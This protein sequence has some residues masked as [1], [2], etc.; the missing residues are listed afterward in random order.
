[1][2]S[3]QIS[4]GNVLVS[5]LANHNTD[6]VDM[7]KKLENSAPSTFTL[8]ADLENE[9]AD[10]KPLECPENFFSNVNASGSFCLPICGEFSFFQREIRILHKV[11]MCVCFIASVIMIVITFTIQRKKT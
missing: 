6:V 11:V 10:G 3:Y 9:I 1:M 5:Y 7:L 2:K 4:A 8:S